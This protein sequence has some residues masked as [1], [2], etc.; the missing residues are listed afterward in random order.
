MDLPA[1]IYHP[2]EQVLNHDGNRN[3]S[4]YIQQEYNEQVPK[5]IYS[6]PSIKE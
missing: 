4:K 2:E 6:R 1:V 5:G 3:T